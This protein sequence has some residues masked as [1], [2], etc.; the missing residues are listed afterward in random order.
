MKHLSAVMNKRPV[1][2]LSLARDLF[3]LTK[4]TCIP[5]FCDRM[6]HRE[7]NPAVH[8]VLS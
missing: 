3:P 6:R 1:Y 8:R 4:N 5:S 2:S 7:E